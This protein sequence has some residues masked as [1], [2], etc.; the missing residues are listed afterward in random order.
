[1]NWEGIGELV[2]LRYKLMWAKTRSRNG[3][4]ALF[5]IGY[6]LFVMIAAMVGLGGL[7][8]GIVAIQTGKAEMLAQVVLSGLLLNAVM[9]TILLGFGMNSVFSEAELRRYPLHQRERFVARHFLG[10]VDP[11]WIL[12]L[13][14]ELGLVLGMFVWG[15]YSLGYGTAAAL[16]LFLCGYLLA[17]AIGAWIDGLMATRSGSAVVMLLI[18]SIAI[19]PRV[20]AAALERNPAAQKQILVALQFTPMFG[21]AAAMTHTGGTAFAGLGLILA[22]SIGL[23]L[24]LV[25][26]ERRPAPRQRAVR[27]TA[28]G[29]KD[30][31]DRFGG[32]F[33]PETAPLVSYWLRFFVRNKRFRMLYLVSFPMAAF[34]TWDIGQLPRGHGN[35]FVAALGTLPIVVFLGPSRIA[36]NLY[37]YMGSAFRRFLLF[38]TDPAASL[39]AGSYVSVLLGGSALI[40]AAIVWAIFAPRPLDFR[41]IV[42]PVINGVTVLFLFNS[43]GLWT[44]L[45]GARPGKY[46]KSLG[47]DMS[48]LGNIV[49]IGSALTCIAVPQM[50]RKAAPAL[51]LRE[52][53]WGLL[54]TA[55]A[56]R[57]YTVSLRAAGAVFSGRRERLLAVLEGKA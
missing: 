12:V 36:V 5:V 39:R 53:W 45:F 41:V 16:L 48:L 13:I 33:P 55:L 8:A 23:A 17:R 38:P 6:L 10:I 18:L 19:L 14:L 30:L 50:L 32:L 42:L 25:W 1:M 21:A 7:G 9:A 56:V 3:K 46:D 43:A 40:P 49:V 4:I 24:F 54:L 15:A 37:G 28:A 22:W 35:L 2:R 44:T 52:D 51:V 31:F 34:L 57:I 47:N 20:V 26:L 29:K 27:G 11:F